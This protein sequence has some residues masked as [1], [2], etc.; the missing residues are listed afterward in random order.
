MEDM[1]LFSDLKSTIQIKPN[2]E[3]VMLEFLNKIYKTYADK[4]ILKG[5]IAL[6]IHL[7]FPNNFRGTRDLDFIVFDKDE[8]EDMVNNM[9]IIV[10]SNNK[11][12]YKFQIAH[13][14]G[15]S[16]NVNS[17]SIEINYYDS[18]NNYID[19]FKIDIN[20]KDNEYAYIVTGDDN[21]KNVYNIYGILTDKLNVLLSKKLCRR[22][23]DLIDVYTIITQEDFNMK[24]LVDWVKIKGLVIT[25][26]KKLSDIF[27]LNTVN[28]SELKHAYLMYKTTMEKPDF[29]E[30]YQTIYDFTFEFYLNYLDLV[31]DSNLCWDSKE[32]KWVNE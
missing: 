11:Y 20:I 6:K 23:K 13:R 5:C 2:I 31:Q 10:S 24:E 30:I 32:R 22:I 21:V 1:N 27:V 29:L 19:T 18:D 25:D 7:K 4:F 17:D 28:I 12:K 26:I 9:C 15:F 3:E 14:R 16:K 8:W